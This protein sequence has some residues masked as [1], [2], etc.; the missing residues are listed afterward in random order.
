MRDSEKQIRTKTRIVVVS[1]S[2]EIAEASRRYPLRGS[3][4]TAASLGI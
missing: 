2:R 1:L 4:T 3:A